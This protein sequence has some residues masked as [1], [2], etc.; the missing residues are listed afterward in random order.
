[1]HFTLRRTRTAVLL[2]M[3]LVAGWTAITRVGNKQIGRPAICSKA[4]R[5]DGQAGGAG[6]LVAVQLCNSKG[7]P[8]LANTPN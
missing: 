3:P 5:T 4:T 6:E 2:V 1:M 7:L 8:C